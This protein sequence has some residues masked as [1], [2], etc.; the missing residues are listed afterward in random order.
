MNNESP[1]DGDVAPFYSEAYQALKTA[2]TLYKEGKLSD[3]I[4]MLQ[5]AYAMMELEDSWPTIETLLRLPMYMQKAGHVQEAWD[6]LN[7]LLVS[8][9]YYPDGQRDALS[10]MIN[11]IIY[12]K[13]RLLLQRNNQMALA[14]VYGIASH[15]SRCLGL[16]RQE[17]LDEYECSIGRKVE[18]ETFVPLLKK[19]GS[20]G[21][22]EELLQHCD[23]IKP[24]L[25]TVDFHSMIVGLCNLLNIDNG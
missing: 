1:L 14:V 23:L 25:A 17:Q 3:A 11:S 22:L 4:V 5:N 16:L 21:R 2:T 6:E 7:R 10:P 13:M 15:Y 8:Y 18:I 19:A 9:N 12:D 24:T 20:S